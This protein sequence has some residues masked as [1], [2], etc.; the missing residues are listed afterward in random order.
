[1]SG[2]AAR[3]GQLL[4]DAPGAAWEKRGNAAWLQCER[5]STWFPVGP[6]MLAPQAPPACCPTCHH[7]FTPGVP[8]H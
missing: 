5:C 4:R 8:A 7:R 2:K 3:P 1:M 6:A